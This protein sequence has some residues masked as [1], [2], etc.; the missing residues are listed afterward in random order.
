[1]HFVKILTSLTPPNIKIWLP[2]PQKRKIYSGLS[3]HDRGQN[4][5]LDSQRFILFAHIQNVISQSVLN[6]SS[7]ILTNGTWK[8]DY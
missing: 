6:Y 2:L 7:Y 1:M 8:D 4:I 3:P 5:K